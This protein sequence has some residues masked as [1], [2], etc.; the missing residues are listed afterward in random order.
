MK[1]NFFKMGAGFLLALSITMIGCQDDENLRDNQI[2][3]E[4]LTEAA[5]VG[6]SEADDAL[7]ISQEVEADLL[8]NSSNSRTANSFG[9]CAVVTNDEESK[10]LTIDFGAGCVGGFGV[11]RSGKIFVNYSGSGIGDNLARRVITFENYVVN[12][13]GVAGTIELGNRNFDGDTLVAVHKL[14]NLTVTFPNEKSV[15][16]N[17]ERTRKWYAGVQDG[18][19]SNNEFIITGSVQGV[20]S[21]GGEFT[22]EIVTPIISKWSC[23]LNDGYFARVAGVVEV[24][25]LRRFVD[26]TR[27]VDYGNGECDNFITVTVGNRT[28]TIS[29]NKAGGNQ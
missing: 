12:N 7:D 29:I 26:R 25:K 15:V 22:H 5:S 11:E 2:A 9:E 18:D 23:R 17:G 1:T 14:I 4:S 10:I 21:D 3:E 6:D 27:R 24:K 20:W 16:Y 19:P 8:N 28:Y 13:K